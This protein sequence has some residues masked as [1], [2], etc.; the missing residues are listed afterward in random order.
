MSIQTLMTAREFEAV[1]GRLGPSELVRGE[2]ITLSPG[3][4]AHSRLTARVASVLSRWA[5]DTGL[6]QVLTGEMGLIVQQGPDTVRGADVVYYS[7]RRLPP[8]SSPEGFCDVA[9]NLVVEIVGKG[10]SWREMVEKVGE[11]L[12]MGV[13]AVWV[14][15]PKSR[16]VHLYR[17]DTEPV[18][19]DRNG[20]L[21]DEPILPG[22]ACTVDDLFA[23]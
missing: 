2:V 15:D 16:R 9:P 4:F 1:A 7:H 11:Y 13:D 21:A 23:R 20:T 6:G 12:R 3:G 18:V 17:P 5:D 22:F 14:I 19:L 8:E 10:Q